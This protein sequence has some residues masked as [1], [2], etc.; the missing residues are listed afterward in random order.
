MCQR[1]IATQRLLLPT[2]QSS[3]VPDR[4]EISF[5]IPLY[6][7]QDNVVPIAR[8]AIAALEQSQRSWELILI[9]DGSGD[10]TAVN[11]APLL[12]SGKVRMVT[13]ESNRGYGAAL[14]SG[15]AAARGSLVAFCDGDGQFDPADLAI[16]LAESS[17]CDLVIGYRRA[18]AEGAA[19]SLPSRAWARLMSM[20]L[21][22]SP[23][24]LDCGFK[25][26]KTDFVNSLNL[27]S[28]GAFISAEI[29]AKA[30][31]AGAQMREVPLDHHR[32]RAGQSTGLNVFVVTR[33]F[34]ELI[35]LYVQ[36]KTWRP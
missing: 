8:A 1:D 7:E 35:R 33:A 2:T 24:D 16:L 14:R 28:D 17:N 10:A 36:I 9:N 32:R 25:L 18:R 5:F 30:S 26:F 15:F 23:Q 11:A 31:R 6:N 3:S 19:R 13:H 4:Q 34:V 22:I 27:Q 12:R 29:L 21:Q 20:L